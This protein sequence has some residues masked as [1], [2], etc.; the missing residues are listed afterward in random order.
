MPTLG[1]IWVRARWDHFRPPPSSTCLK[2][3][4]AAL[5][6][7]NAGSSTDGQ[8]AYLPIGPYSVDLVLSTSSLRTNTL[9]VLGKKRKKKNHFSERI[10]VPK[11][12]RWVDTAACVSTGEARG[13]WHHQLFCGHQ[14]I[15]PGPPASQPVPP[16][17]VCK[18]RHRYSGICIEDTRASGW[19]INTKPTGPEGH[20]KQPPSSDGRAN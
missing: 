9:F 13:N 17:W 8:S 15:M 19:L 20:P 10:S 3:C 14:L 2:L 16:G 4:T 5:G 1:G 12:D 7:F 11:M 6:E 18:G